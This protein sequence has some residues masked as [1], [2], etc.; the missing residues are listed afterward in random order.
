MNKDI[1]CNPIFFVD[2]VISHSV[3]F[4]REM[5][6]ISQFHLHSNPTMTTLVTEHARMVTTMAL[7]SFNI[8]HW[9]KPPLAPEEFLFWKS[10]FEDVLFVNGLSDIVE[11]PSWL[12]K[13]WKTQN[14]QYGN[15]RIALFLSGLKPPQVKPDMS[16]SKVV[17]PEVILE[18]RLAPTMSVISKGIRGELHYM[19]KRNDQPMSEYL[20]K[21]KSLYSIPSTSGRTSN[22]IN[23]I[24]S[25]RP[26]WTWVWCVHRLDSHMRYNY[27]YSNV[28]F[29]HSTI[30]SIEMK[31]GSSCQSK[32]ISICSLLEQR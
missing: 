7:M 18:E 28:S 6:L 11:S 32:W 30:T 3:S 13:E 19:R 21:I 4:A 5:T 16:S 15:E 31:S 29:T 1:D 8:K 23:I 27:V 17:K 25:H 9:F 12:P 20:N 26:T 24:H 2:L 22:D 10:T 14:M